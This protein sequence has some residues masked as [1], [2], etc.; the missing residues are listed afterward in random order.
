MAG[1]AISD[2]KDLAGIL[3]ERPAIFDESEVLALARVADARLRQNMAWDVD[4]G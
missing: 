1:V 2:G 3:R 4:A